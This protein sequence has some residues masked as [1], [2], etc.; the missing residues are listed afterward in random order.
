MGSRVEQGVELVY[1]DHLFRERQV[2]ISDVV[3]FCL[4]QYLADQSQ[5]P[6]I[7]DHGTNTINTEGQTYVTAI[8]GTGTPTKSEPVNWLALEFYTEQY[9][10]QPPDDE[11]V[12]LDGEAFLGVS[13]AML[14]FVGGEIPNPDISGWRGL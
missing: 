4:S 12:T 5:G 9:D 8:G 11:K 10:Q 2:G 1:P 7:L 14:R 6:R 13:G 3:L